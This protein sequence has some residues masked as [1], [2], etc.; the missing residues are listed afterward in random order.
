MSWRVLFGD[1]LRLLRYGVKRN[2]KRK[3]DSLEWLR[4]KGLN[5]GEIREFTYLEFD[6]LAEYAR[7]LTEEFGGFSVRTD[8]GKETRALPINLPML[9]DPSIEELT[10]FVREHRDDFTY[11]LYQ[12]RDYENTVWQGRFWLEPGNVLKGEVNA[13]DKK[14]NWREALKKTKNLECVTCG[15]GNYDTRFMKIRYDLIQ[16]GVGLYVMLDVSAYKE[17]DKT[18]VYYKGMGEDH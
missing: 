13:V 11:I 3:I 7:K 12:K 5:V 1:S 15:P 10:S 18:V 14:L 9:K 17:G 16:A 2:V 4:S 8:F 6:E